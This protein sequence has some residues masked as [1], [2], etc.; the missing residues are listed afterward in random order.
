MITRRRFAS[1]HWP[2]WSANVPGDGCAESSSGVGSGS[3]LGAFLYG[4]V[5]RDWWLKLN[6]N[7]EWKMEKRYSDML[8]PGNDIIEGII[9]ATSLID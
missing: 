5:Q 1:G 9:F 2:D 3:F 4:Y 8:V 6:L 7:L